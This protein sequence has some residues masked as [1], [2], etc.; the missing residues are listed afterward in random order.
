MSDSNSEFLDDEEDSEQPRVK[1]QFKGPPPEFT[2]GEKC[3]HHS[4]IIHSYHRLSHIRLCTV[5]VQ[6]TGW[7]GDDIK[8][9][10]EALQQIQSKIL[11]AQD[12]NKQRKMQ[13]ASL[14]PRLF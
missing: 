1:S 12:L 10:P 14:M 4:M 3:P 9:F 8:I 6:E 11:A 2:L 5:C 7:T 13:V